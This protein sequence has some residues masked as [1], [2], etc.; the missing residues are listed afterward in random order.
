M[1]VLFG[2]LYKKLILNLFFTSVG[3][4]VILVKSGFHWGMAL[5]INFLQSLGAVLGFFIGVAVSADSTAS[6]NWI[7]AITAGLF[8][9]IALTDLVRSL[10]IQLY[11]CRPIFTKRSMPSICY[12]PLSAAIN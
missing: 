12:L 4:F 3:D 1:R 6:S 11:Y 9:Y 7:L 10:T 8:F 5:F 2:D